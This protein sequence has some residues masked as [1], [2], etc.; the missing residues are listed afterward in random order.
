MRI[1]IGIDPA[2]STGMCILTDNPEV[3]PIFFEGG[4]DGVERIPLRGLA[5]GEVHIAAELPFVGDNKRGAIN[6]GILAGALAER[7][8]AS[9]GV[10]LTAVRWFEPLA[11][12]KEIGCPQSRDAAKDWCHQRA[13]DLATR[14]GQSLVTPRGRRMLD[15]GEA[16]G[17][18]CALRRVVERNP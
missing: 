11:W 9:V 15:A 8:S 6:Q 18:A 13:H 16:W 10:P 3:P 12:R 17:I 14:F 7:V 5:E 4:E 1:F 2:K